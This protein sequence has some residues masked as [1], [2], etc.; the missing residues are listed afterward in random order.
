VSY[1]LYLLR[2]DVVGDDPAAA[3]ERLE[4]LAEADPPLPTPEEEL[5]LRQLA[6]DL[7]AASPGLDLSEP[8]QGFGGRSGNATGRLTAGGRAQEP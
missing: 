3:F 2:R 8:E 7:Q 1:D 6:S 4:E 5:Q